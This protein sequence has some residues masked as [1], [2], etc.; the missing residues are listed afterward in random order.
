MATEAIKQPATDRQLAYID[1]LRKEVGEKSPE[2][3]DEMTSFE[4]STLISELLAKTHKNGTPNGQY[5]KAK[6]NEP[7]LGMAIKEC[8]RAWV[9][10]G[11]SVYAERREQ[12]IKKAIETYNLFTEISERL[13]ESAG[14][15][16]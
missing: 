16:T 7:R 4:A 3:K 14:G 2:T 12:F 9:S 15:R 13:Q 5:M 11:W 10:L 1:S 8:Y 6:I